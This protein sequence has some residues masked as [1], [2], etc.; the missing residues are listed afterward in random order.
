MQL[1]IQ[2]ICS[3]L[4]NVVLDCV[5]L[6]LKLYAIQ[7]VIS[8]PLR[9]K[10]TMGQLLLLSLC[11]FCSFFSYVGGVLVTNLFSLLLIYF[12]YSANY[13]TRGAF[14]IIFLICSSLMKF[15]RVRVIDNKHW[16][17]MR[18]YI[19]AHDVIRVM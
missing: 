10:L 1:E 7:V 9:I 4:K 11:N 6:V 16:W 15:W 5:L 19:D 2:K 13:D 18:V 3:H 17:T 8:L 14:V 12:G